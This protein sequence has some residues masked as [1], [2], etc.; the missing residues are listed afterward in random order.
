ML[1]TLTSSPYFALAMIS[2][3]L[4]ASFTLIS[5]NISFLL[6]NKSLTTLL[7]A[8]LTRVDHLCGQIEGC[9]M[10]N[11][12]LLQ[13]LIDE[14]A[15]PLL[16]E[17]FDR[18][19]KDSQ[20]LYQNKW[21][22]EP[23]AYLNFQYLLSNKQYGNLHNDNAF[24]QLAFGL[25]FSAFSLL[26]P[27]SLGGEHTFRILPFAIL[28]A[29][30]SLAFF[31][32][33]FYRNQYYR[34][35]LSKAIEKLSQTIARRVPVFSNLA[36]SAV[37]VDAFLQYDKQM[38]KS[39]TRLSS[40][41]NS[42]LNQELIKAISDTIKESL[43]NS[44]APAILD[45]HDLLKALSISVNEKQEKG[46]SL[47][48]HQFTE[49]IS[50][51]LVQKLDPFYSQVNAYA[52]SLGKMSQEITGFLQHIEAYEKKQ[53]LLNET[54][55]DNIQAFGHIHNELC[56][57]IKELGRA[58]AQMV[59]ACERLSELQGQG[60]HSLVAYIQHFSN[61]VKLFSEKLAIQ[62][63]ENREEHIRSRQHLDSF[64][65]AQNKALENHQM[66]FNT[67][68]TAGQ[69]LNRQADFINRQLESL[70]TQLNQSV[71]L[72]NQEMNKGVQ[73]TLRSFDENLAEIT[74]R[75]SISVSEIK[76]NIPKPERVQNSQVLE[77]FSSPQA[78]VTSNNEEK[79]EK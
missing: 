73:Q 3:L 31:C 71:L 30:I 63:Q 12:S 69:T 47:L 5:V 76:Q 44:L 70:S 25:L 65:V 67:M 51:I 28:P 14:E 32:M 35:E 53:S 43:D 72:F 37:L 79:N 74:D 2:V 21:T 34:H 24:R 62:L 42:L 60:E 48:A 19:V 54:L 39:V 57:Q 52:L 11:L 45:S 36:G 29:M 50:S 18:Y 23:S 8:K 38:S 56:I 77:P 4:I 6:A 59:Q 61:Q 58:E 33:F 20:K 78:S 16:T 68:L 15:F 46:L 9:Q 10:E 22:L 64:S 41:I 1:E 55:Q 40:S 17:A 49:E 13:S 66:Q 26:I 75:L 7:T 27:L